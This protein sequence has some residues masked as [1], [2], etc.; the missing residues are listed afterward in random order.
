M[1]NFN[2]IEEK[3]KLYSKQFRISEPYGH[4]IIDN[5]CKNTI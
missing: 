1:I 4:V 2:Q 3:V 5:F